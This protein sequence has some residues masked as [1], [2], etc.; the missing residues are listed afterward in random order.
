M[1]HTS[2]PGF[3]QNDILNGKLSGGGGG[4]WQSGSNVNVHMIDTNRIIF[5]VRMLNDKCV[6]LL[7][8]VY[9]PFESDESMYKVFANQ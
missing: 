8:N 1:L 9:L 3:D 5:T 4:L 7:S 6:L 2:V